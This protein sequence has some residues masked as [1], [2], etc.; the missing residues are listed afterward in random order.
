MHKLIE[1][2]GGKLKELVVSPKRV[3]ELKALSVELPSW[4]LTPRQMYDLELLMN[5]AFSPLEG[6]MGE[7]DYLSVVENMRLSDGTLW[8]IPVVLDVDQDF[9]KQITGGDHLVLRSPEGIALAVMHVEDLWEPDLAAEAER[10]YGTKDNAHPGVN[11]L[12]SHNNP[13]CL[14]GAI[15]GLELPDHYSFKEFRHT[16]AELRE[17]FAGDGWDRVIAFQTRNPLH[18]AHFELT[19]QAQHK[20]GAKLLLHPAVGPTKPGDVEYQTRVRCYQLLIDKYPENTAVL[21]LLPLAMR[22]AGPR[23]ALWHAIIRKNYG[24]TH[25]IV[26]R[27]HAGAGKDAQGNSFYGPYDAQELVKKH[28]S[29]LGMEVVPFEE[30]VYVEET[31]QYLP[32]SE[33]P[34]GTKSLNLSGSEL[35]ERLQK[36]LPIPDWFSFPEVIEELRKAYPERARQ[37]FTVFF[38]GLSGSGKST[39]A[40]ALLAKLMEI[41]G[42]PVTLLDGDIVRKHLSSEL[43]FSKE[44]RDLNI[45]RIGY[46]ASEITKNNG[47]AICAPIAPYDQ[48]RKDVREMIS[49]Y[50]GFILAHVST[51]MEVCELRD[52]KGLYAKARAGLIKGFTGIDDPYEEPED[53]EL[54]IDT[55]GLTPGEA[56][57]NI[58]DFLKE[59]GYFS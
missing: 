29:E 42:R 47:I 53:A 15:E 9:A 34:S 2:H 3:A 1:P 56:A 32:S 21:S 17:I 45:R 27:D 57:Q 37:G 4:D 10:V 24:C 16:P 18:R 35:R 33:V 25:F 41:G 38:T 6:F 28:E 14:G 52:R 12:M 49:Q 5:G 19:K 59:E 31:G 20:T 8:P 46:V 22:M 54:V 58:I 55:S 44:H 39:L 30:M 13:V 48:V 26:G 43:T 50:G 23:E 7:D 11:Y 40:N 51:P 36:G